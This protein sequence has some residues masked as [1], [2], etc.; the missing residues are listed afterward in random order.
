[1]D[2]NGIRFTSHHDAE[3]TMAA[4][5]MSKSKRRKKKGVSRRAD[6][7]LRESVANVFRGARLTPQE[8]A[9][10]D[11]LRARDTAEKKPLEVP[12]AL[13]DH[14]YLTPRQV[15]K[16]LKLRLSEVNNP[17]GWCLNGTMGRTAAGLIP[18]SE[19]LRHLKRMRRSNIEK[20]TRDVVKLITGDRGYWSATSPG[21][22]TESLVESRSFLPIETV[23]SELGIS[24]AA[25][26]RIMRDEGADGLYS[27]RH[28]LRRGWCVTR[29][30]LDAY[31]RKLAR[32]AAE[33]GEALTL[34]QTAL[35]LN[36]TE[37]TIADLVQSLELLTIEPNGR[38]LIPAS[39]YRR[40][41][42]RATKGAA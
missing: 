10:I 33:K 28:E 19:A 5:A 12:H 9:I 39:E 7:H 22:F 13:L 1:M 38:K 17:H 27:Q 29:E 41:M 23:A 20:E 30:E 26:D 18:T 32:R 14:G 2:A 40:F 16:L 3:E 24:K 4:T 34:A 36:T 8:H 6:D 31:K 37:K 35:V 11:A 21:G 42:R 15:A 25:A